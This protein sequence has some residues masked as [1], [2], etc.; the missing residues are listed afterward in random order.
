MSKVLNPKKLRVCV[1]VLCMLLL[2]FYGPWGEAETEDLSWKLMVN[3]SSSAGWGEYTAVVAPRADRVWISGGIDGFLYYDGETLHEQ[4]VAGEAG[5]YVTGDSMSAVN[6]NYIWAV[7]NTYSESHML[8]YDGDSW[9]IKQTIPCE[10][11]CLDTVDNRHAWAGGCRGGTVVGESGGFG[12]QVIYFYDGTSWAEQWPLG[13]VEGTVGVVFGIGAADESNVWASPANFIGTIHYDGN[14]W[15]QIS[16]EGWGYNVAALDETH[17]WF[18]GGGLINFYDGKTFSEQYYSETY[19]NDIFALDENHVWAVGDNGLILFFDGDTWERQESGTT[20]DLNSVTATDAEHAWAVGD[21]GTILY[22]KDGGVQPGPEPDP[23]YSVSRQ[24]A[25]DSKGSS[26]TS[27]NWYLA[28]G[29][30]GSDESGGFETWVLVQNPGGQ[31]AQVS[32]DYHT[33]GGERQGPDISVAPG[34]RATVEVAQTVPGE[35]DVSTVVTSD[36][37]VIAERSMYWNGGGEQRRAAHDSV[38]VTSPDTEWYLAEG[39]TG[40]DE[41]GTFETWVLVQNPGDDTANVELYYQTPV[42]EK[43]G[44]EVSLGA[45]SRESV[46]VAATV[47]AE[48]SVSTRVV[49]DM[50]VIAERAMYWNPAGGAIRQAAHNSI[51]VAAPGDEWYLAEGSTGTSDDGTFETWV[52]VQNPGDAKAEVDLY[53]QTTTGEVKGPHLTLAPYSRD[54]V[55]VAATVP[56]EFSVSTKVVSDRPVIAERA[57]Y[58]NPVTGV[59][60]QAAHDSVGVAEAADIWYLAEGSTGDDPSGTFETWVLVQNPGSEKAT[61]VLSFM[62]A[63]GIVPGPTVELEAKTRKTVNVADYANGQASVSTEITSDRP[64]IAERAVY[65]NLR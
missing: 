44:P 10:I 41:K 17:V 38:G 21:N 7:N 8:F 58:W 49:S 6:E 20:E 11:D 19:Q 62:T 37:P 61:A 15:E 43:K 54:T 50:P 3:N 2:V 23:G 65:Y 64:V 1:V 28:E 32:I 39:S 25:H 34:T 63:N 33:P 26:E 12:G 52:L 13:E 31:P 57:M 35:W 46:N 51:G 48:W 60:R 30:T 45:H 4:I 53:Y 42:G 27:K 36:Q 59:Y 29:S 5:R 22:T 14:K 24:C 9:N 18:S 16:E 56:G 40:L 47:P 55:D